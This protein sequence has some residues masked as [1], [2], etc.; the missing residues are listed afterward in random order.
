MMKKP[1]LDR[2]QNMIEL[3]G[4]LDEREEREAREA[5]FSEYEQTIGN[6]R[7]DN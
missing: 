1:Q 4:S 6:L 3:L 5:K 7:K 2:S